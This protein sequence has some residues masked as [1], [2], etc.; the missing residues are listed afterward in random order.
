MEYANA[1][2]LAILGVDPGYAILGWG[3]VEYRASRHRLMGYGTVETSKDLPMPER[4]KELYRGLTGVIAK[5]EPDVA[6]VEELFFNSNQKTAIKVGEAR[7]AAVLACANAGLDV[8]EYTPLQIKQALTGYGRAEKQQIQEMV[9]QVLGLVKAPTPDD[10]ADAVACAI[11][12]ANAS[13]HIER[14]GRFAGG[15]L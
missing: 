12:H 2:S 5:Y 3:V 11:C 14:V 15:G 1:K 10:A 8:Y 9:R 7:G 4:L 13:A 6:A